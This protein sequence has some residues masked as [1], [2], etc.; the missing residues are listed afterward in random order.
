MKW[1]NGFKTQVRGRQ[2]ECFR[3]LQARP[4]LLRLLLVLRLETCL[5]ALLERLFALQQHRL[6]GLL[7]GEVVNQAILG[8]GY[9]LGEET[10]HGAV[11]PEIG[12]VIVGEGAAL[13]AAAAAAA[14][15]GEVAEAAELGGEAEGE[16]LGRARRLGA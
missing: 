13:T 11:G 5:N 10:L 4:G 3:R 12:Q 8:R 7:L 15:P 9:G 16:S 2:R 1:E 6:P 14:A